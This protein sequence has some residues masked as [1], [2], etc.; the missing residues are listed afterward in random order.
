MDSK[1][2]VALYVEYMFTW[3]SQEN[4]HEIDSSTKT[5]NKIHLTLTGKEAVQLSQR[6]KKEKG[7]F[8]RALF[9]KAG[10]DLENRSL[11]MYDYVTKHPNPAGLKKKSGLDW[12][13]A[14]RVQKTIKDA[15]VDTELYKKSLATA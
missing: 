4:Y 14:K 12:N 1:E 10:V 2:F 15:Q 8:I 6:N 11:I 3:N 7:Q 5:P 9:T 13:E